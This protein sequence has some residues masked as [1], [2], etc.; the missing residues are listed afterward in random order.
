MANIK[1]QHKFIFKKSIELNNLKEVKG[2]DFESLK[3]NNSL[4]EFISFFNAI[5]FQASE[6]GKAIEVIKQM[7]K[8]NALIYLGFTS[9]MISSG[10][11]ETITF[12]VKN[13]LVDILVTTAGGIEEDIIKT[14]KPF[15]LGTFN[16]SDTELRAKGINRIGDIFV[17]NERYIWFESFIQPILKRL[18]GKQKQGTL[19]NS[20]IFVKE[21]AIE[22]EKSKDLKKNES[23]I[24]WAYKNSIPIFC[25]SIIDGS[26]GDM[27]YFF[28]Q[29]HPE[30][31]IDISNDKVE[32]DNIT[33]NAQKTGVIILGGGIVKHF[34]LN[35]NLMRGG[36]D[37]AVYI[38]TGFEVDGSVA[39]AK[40]EEAKSWGKATKKASSANV[41]CDATIAFP[42]IVAGAFLD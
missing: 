14:H 36:T 12:L 39:G 42:L 30:F 41:F 28:K 16:V 22:L 13:R 4:K 17:P 33:I 7:R 37:F 18:L 19:I 24:Y 40:P 3:K 11:R 8:E 10:L 34:I 38:T 6:L 2:H 25:P 15:L 20:R 26:I 9:N 1:R 23:Y 29:K 32:L 31:S 21:L 5:G 35:S 27:I